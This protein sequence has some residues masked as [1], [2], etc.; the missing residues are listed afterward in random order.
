MGDEGLYEFIAGDVGENDGDDG[1][2]L[3]DEG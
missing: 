2:K 1:V 3:G